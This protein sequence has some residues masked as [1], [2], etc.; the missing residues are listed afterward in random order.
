MLYSVAMGILVV[1]LSVLLSVNLMQVIRTAQNRYRQTMRAVDQANVT[2][3]EI[4]RLLAG[5]S[6][7][8][9]G[10]Q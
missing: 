2:A 9:K 8:F 5:R 6:F 4:Q 7:R 1:S 3:S 10:W